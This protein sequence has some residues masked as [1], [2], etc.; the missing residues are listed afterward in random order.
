MAQ[1]AVK[2]VDRVGTASPLKARVLSSSAMQM[3]L[4]SFDNRGQ[5]YM[6]FVPRGITINTKYTMVSWASI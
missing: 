6:H 2:T 1:K 3:V 4:K 5:V